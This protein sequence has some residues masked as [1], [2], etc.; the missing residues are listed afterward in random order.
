MYRIVIVILIYY[1]H[2]SRQIVRVHTSHSDFSK[3]YFHITRTIY[4]RL[5]FPSHIISSAFL[6]KPYI[7]SSFPIRATCVVHLNHLN[8]IVIITLGQEYKLR[9]S[10]LC[11]FLSEYSPRRPVLKYYSLTSLPNFRLVKKYR[12]NYR[13]VYSSFKFLDSRLEAKSSGLNSCKRYL[14]SVFY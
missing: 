8:L 2:K 13:F 3:I 1:R 10:A 11:S 9:S 14:N 6:L 7:Q 12:Q 4:R 5:S